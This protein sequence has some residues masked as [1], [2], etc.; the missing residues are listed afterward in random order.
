MFKLSD[1]TTHSGT[2]LA[3]SLNISRAAVW[4][5]IKALRTK[6]IAIK[7]DAG[8][9][10][11]IPGG[12]QLLDGSAIKAE[13]ETDIL[14]TVCLQIL[15]TIP[16]TNNWLLDQLS[17]GL[18]SGTVCIAEHQTAGRGTKGRQWLSPYGANLY[19]SLYWNFDCGPIE[20][21]G[22]SLAIAAIISKTLAHA[23]AEEIKIKWPNDFYTPRGKL[24][25]I[26]I[27]M[28]AEMTGPS[29]AIIGMG[30]N[31]D[32]PA[33]NHANINQAV[34]CLRDTGVANTL[35]RNQ[36]AARVINAMVEGCIQY[37]REGFAAF[38]ED[39]R[40]RDMMIGQQV[41]LTNGNRTITGKACGVNNMGAIELQTE[42]GQQ[43]FSSGEITL[44]IMR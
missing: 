32:M 8:N 23:G 40:S 1:G 5:H 27:D 21:S 24:G 25:G 29:H 44:R 31:I 17:T 15:D 22:L 20:L 39:W 13:L 30:L 16:S 10:Y 11:H 28:V 35:N 37:S 41:R 4:K 6:G 36:L 7:S 38:S 12:L 19:L 34:A 2:T 18:S 33:K 14:Q 43:T 42:S 9:G 3:Q 26:L